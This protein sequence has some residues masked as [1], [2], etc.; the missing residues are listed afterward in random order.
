MIIAVI[1]AVAVLLVG[2]Y[3]IS[4]FIGGRDAYD[5]PNAPVIA[6]EI[7]TRGAQERP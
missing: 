6:D 1:L 7:I 3:I 2:G 5:N 4:R